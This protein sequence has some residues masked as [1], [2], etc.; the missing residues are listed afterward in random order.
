MINIFI[1]PTEVQKLGLRSTRADFEQRINQTA[2]EGWRHGGGGR[3]YG[4]P[5][6]FLTRVA[7]IRELAY[8]RNFR[9]HE[10]PAG[11]VPF[12]DPWAPPI[13]E[14]LDKVLQPGRPWAL[15][16]LCS[17]TGQLPLQRKQ[18]LVGPKLDVVVS[19][20]LRAA[21]NLAG[22]AYV[23]TKSFWRSLYP[24]ALHVYFDLL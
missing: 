12:P 6:R 18:H 10:V 23:H 3:E 21:F 5:G 22:L 11:G 17:C 7:E 20:D 15:L 13:R 2:G 14:D 19:S 1:R 24:V 9:R 16:H 8:A 4:N